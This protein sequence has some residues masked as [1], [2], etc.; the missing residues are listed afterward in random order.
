VS[1][2]Q[3]DLKLRAKAAEAKGDL[4]E[5]V[6]LYVQAEDIEE[7]GRVY[8]TAG[9]FDQA[10]R[11]LF[12]AVGLPLEQLGKGTPEQKKLAVRAGI[13]LVKAGE[14][15]NAVAI[16]L[17]VGDKQRAVEAL[18]KGG[19]AVGAAKLRAQL[20]GGAEVRA[21]TGTGAVA[22]AKYGA[23]MRLEQEGNLAGALAAYIQSKAYSDA[24]R[25]ARK[26][27]RPAEAGPFFEEA[28]MYYE[29]AV[30]WNEAQDLRRCIDALVRVQR[31]H[32]R[33]RGCAVK[34]IELSS[35]QNEIGFEL[36]QFVA[37]FLST[38]PEN[39]QELDAFATLGRLYSKHGFPDNARECFRKVIAVAPQHPAAKMLAEL[40]REAKGTNLAYE[41]IVRE[42]A[43][44]RGDQLRSQTAWGGGTAVAQVLPDLPDL[45]DLPPLPGAPPPGLPPQP[46]AAMA[47][48]ELGMPPQRPGTG[49]QPSA[50]AA[51]QTAFG[52]PPPGARPG[53]GPSAPGTQVGRPGGQ[54]PQYASA[55]PAAPVSAPAAAP[56]APEQGLDLSSGSVIAD[57]YRLEKQIGQGGTASVFRAHDL[58]LE[59]TVA[60]KVFTVVIDDPDLIRRFKQE[61]SVARQLSHPNIVRLHDIG[62]HRGFRFLTM[63]LLPGTDLSSVLAKG[64]PPMVKALD[65]LVQACLGLQ[66][67]HERGIVHRDIKPEN[68]FVTD[69]GVL[70]VMDFGIAKSA[71]AQKRTQAGFI[72]GTPPY[73]S[74]EQIS[75][76]A[77]VKHTADLYSLGIVAYE[78]FTGELP[79]MHEEMMPLLMMHLTAAPTHPM[80][81]N[82]KIP[83]A[84]NDLILRL[85][86]K[87]PKARIQSCREL[88]DELTRI[89][90][91]VEAADRK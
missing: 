7:A 67:A 14:T 30:C 4:A 64:R 72:A 44:F 73:M 43:A 82:T 31:D 33:Y 35:Q 51:Y 87:D 19:D 5:A 80:E 1:K 38:G 6:K 21:T 40:E 79:F 84:L 20:E 34:A 11:L 28:G 90:P 26:L 25:V 89:R 52:A 27:G 85:L 54:Q 75:G 76:F 60:L 3:T 65:Y 8:I 10:G 77:D 9:R 29:A 32:P 18:E 78:M 59:E 74:P 81:R 83:P 23:G 2:H 22:A 13:C 17:G 45:P 24:G 62:T 57:R 70:K 86:E 48:T 68:F 12:R 39:A 71:Q 61:L 42:D 36:D 50:H 47:R 37:R 66:L 56:A 41:K 91:L 55:Q 69:K 63:E 53:A 58:E 49:P 88:A 46:N 15:H 16:F